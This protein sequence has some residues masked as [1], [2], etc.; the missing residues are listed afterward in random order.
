MRNNPDRK[1]DLAD[2]TYGPADKLKLFEESDF[3]VCALPGTA[4]TENFC[5]AAEFAAMK[6]TSIF[7]SIGRGLAVD[8]DALA[9]ALISKSIGGAAVDVF[10][11]E[12]LPKTSDLWKCDNLIL[13][14]CIA[15]ASARATWPVCAVA[16][17]ARAVTSATPPPS[18][19]GR[20]VALGPGVGVARR[21]HGRGRGGALQATALL[22]K[23]TRR[24]AGGGGR[25]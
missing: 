16:Q 4:A 22:P 9:A 7:L 24:G 11:Q 13:T 19:P 20:G 12:P 6:K 10:K 23:V 2:V 15:R 17:P 8:E 5:G 21:R 1:S 14:V 25:G 3:V 18:R